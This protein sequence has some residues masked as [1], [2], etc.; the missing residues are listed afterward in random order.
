[1]LYVAKSGFSED[2]LNSD[3]WCLT[4][5]ELNELLSTLGMK[6]ISHVFSQNKQR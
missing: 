2:A 4:Y 6:K 5:R 1:M 3:V